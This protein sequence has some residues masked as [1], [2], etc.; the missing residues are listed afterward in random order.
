[1]QRSVVL[2]GDDPEQYDGET[3]PSIDPYMT[4]SSWKQHHGSQ[5]AKAASTM[6]KSRLS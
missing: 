6:G 2:N 4:G 3:N 5:L 1:M